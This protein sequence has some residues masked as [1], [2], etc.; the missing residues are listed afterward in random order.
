[1]IYFPHPAAPSLCNCRFLDISGPVDYNGAY[2]E[3]GT[4]TDYRVPLPPLHLQIHICIYV[5]SAT[6]AEKP[7]ENS[8][9]RKLL[10]LLSI[11]QESNTHPPRSGQDY[12]VMWRRA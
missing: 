10:V 4:T 7:D 6:V 1:M 8:E 3:G 2:Y 5:R 9:R 11:Q 12:V